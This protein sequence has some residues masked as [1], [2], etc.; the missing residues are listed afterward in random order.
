L[1]ICVVKSWSMNSPLL[2]SLAVLCIVGAPACEDCDREACDALNDQSNADITGLAGVV[3]EHQFEGDVPADTCVP[4]SY[5][6]VALSV[7]P[8]ADLVATDAAAAEVVENSDPLLVINADGPYSQ[9]L[10]PGPYLV[11]AKRICF[12]VAVTENEVTTANI[13]QSDST[14]L[15]VV[16]REQSAS[17]WVDVDTFFVS[18]AE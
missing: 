5:G 16:I 8:T 6:M 7:W 14:L 13:R 18:D 10:R 17:S 11:C 4:C 15:R 12:S 9:E 3:A 2:C 1:T